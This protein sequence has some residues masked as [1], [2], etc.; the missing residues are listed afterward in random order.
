MD[1]GN[2]TSNIT[3]EKKRFQT[4]SPPST[5][6]YLTKVSVLCQLGYR[7][8]DLSV[9]NSILCSSKGSWSGTPSCFGK[10]I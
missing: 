2:P 8:S 1:C 10:K 5:G 7:F 3:I 4:G 9:N 6:Q